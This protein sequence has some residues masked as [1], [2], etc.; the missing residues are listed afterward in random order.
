MLSISP[1]G[2][3]VYAERLYTCLMASKRRT[4]FFQ[5]G[6]SLGG[7][8]PRTDSLTLADLPL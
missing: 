3:T 6:A 8:I 2:P 5:F 7:E 1:K 4:N